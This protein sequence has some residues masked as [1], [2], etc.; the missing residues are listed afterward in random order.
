MDNLVSNASNS[1]MIK[2]ERQSASFAESY[3]R[4]LQGVI[5]DTLGPT[6][7]SQDELKLDHPIKFRSITI[8]KSNT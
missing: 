6:R 7:T 2:N 8:P 3:Y 5:L 4:F 1:E